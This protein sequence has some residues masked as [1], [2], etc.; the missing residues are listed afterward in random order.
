MMHEWSQTE[1]PLSS[2]RNVFTSS[3]K[4]R[5]RGNQMLVAV[6]FENR[7]LTYRQ[8]NPQG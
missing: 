8:L 5:L 6:V 3:L 7:Q 4:R 2:G 1:G